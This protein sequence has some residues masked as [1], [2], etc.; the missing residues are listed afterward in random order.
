MKKVF[1]ILT[2]TSLLIGMM[3]CQAEKEGDKEEKQG[4]ANH[5]MNERSFE[6]L[7]EDFEDTARISWQKPDQVISLLGDLGGARVMDIGCG[8]GYFAFRLVEAGA[9]VICADVDDRFLDYVRKKRERVGI[10]EEKLQLKK[11]PYDSPD[12]ETSSIDV[13]VMVNTYHHIEN[14]EAYFTRLLDGMKEGGRLMIV[15]F[16]AG[17][18][19]LGPPSDMKLSAEEVMAEL[20]SAGFSNFLVNEEMLPYQYILVA[21]K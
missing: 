12:V 19:P 8:T 3:A 18:L 4:H 21:E 13:A 9:T 6:E 11:L 5:Q 7:V 10:N 2:L 20:G 1:H 15:D 17:E 14:R 16:L